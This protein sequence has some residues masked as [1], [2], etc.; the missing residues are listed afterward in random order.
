MAN[1]PFPPLVNTRKELDKA[2]DKEQQKRVSGKTPY[3]KFP[4]EHKTGEESGLEEGDIELLKGG[5]LARTMHMGLLHDLDLLAATI[6]AMAYSGTEDLHPGTQDA[7][8]QATVACAVDQDGTLIIASN[9]VSWK[10][11]KRLENYGPQQRDQEKFRGKHEELLNAARDRLREEHGGKGGLSKETMHDIKQKAEQ[12]SLSHHFMPFNEDPRNL[13]QGAVLFDPL[14][15][16]RRELR[17][18]SN[19][20]VSGCV[21]LQE[22]EN[23]HAEMQLLLHFLEKGH[24]HRPRFNLI[25]VSKPCCRFCA[26]WLLSYGVQFTCYHEITPHIWSTPINLGQG[27]KEHYI[28]NQ[29]EEGLPSSGAVHVYREKL[30][31]NLPPGEAQHGGVEGWVKHFPLKEK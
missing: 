30:L 7:I 3:S 5:F 24:R 19:G 22:V 12:F 16:I 23:V 18:I 21:A 2:D 31:E 8:N 25:G 15:E 11:K 14:E 29:W 6:L 26:F 1:T 20:L 13:N 17:K 27:S 9:K 10:P 4:V 28:P